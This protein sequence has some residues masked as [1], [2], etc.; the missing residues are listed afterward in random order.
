MMSTCSYPSKWEMGTPATR[1]LLRLVQYRVYLS[2]DGSI[3]CIA[4]EGF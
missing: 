4:A 2:D 1:V 3:G